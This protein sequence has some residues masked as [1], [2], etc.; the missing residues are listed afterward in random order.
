[1]NVQESYSR[2]LEHGT[3]LESYTMLIAYLAPPPAV[4]VAQERDLELSVRLVSEGLGPA[5]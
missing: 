1:M 3:L 4:L 5:L 2:A